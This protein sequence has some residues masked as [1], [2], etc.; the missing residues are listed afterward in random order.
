[1]SDASPTLSI[2]VATAGRPTLR[3]TL[4]SVAPQLKP[5]DEIMVVCDASGDA[6][7]TPRMDAMPRAR[8]T[9]LAFLDDDD[10]YAPDALE[11]MRRFAREHPG[12]IGIF[13][14]KHPAGTTH[15]RG[16]EPV[17]RYANVSTQ[18]FLVPNVP[19]KLGRW[20]RD[21]PRPDGKGHYIGD[22]AFITETAQ[23]QGDPVFVDEV[24]VY[25]RPVD[26][27]RRL[28]IRVRYF[29]ALRT[30]ARRLLRATR[31]GA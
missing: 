14:M 15:W 21:V 8:G 10:V 28:W 31:D 25:A 19:G 4:A 1:V 2:I 29:A 5:G 11:K 12:R 26:P 18:T 6:G 17:L 7:D 30:R 9:H 3:R 27:L 16:G 13:K 20:H 24:T 22:Y 23:L